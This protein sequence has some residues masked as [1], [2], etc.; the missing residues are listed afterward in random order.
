METLSEYEQLRLNNINRNKAVMKGLG[1]DTGTPT[2][3][4]KVWIAP[5]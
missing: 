4:R 1:L 3:M 2:R 5:P